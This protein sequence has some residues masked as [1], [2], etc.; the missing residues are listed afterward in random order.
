[1]TLDYENIMSSTPG[2]LFFTFY[3]SKVIFI[4]IYLL[5]TPRNDEKQSNSL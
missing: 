4:S 2:E 5:F 3:K 1:M